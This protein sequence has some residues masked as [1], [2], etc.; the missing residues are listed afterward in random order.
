MSINHWSLMN[1]TKIYPCG[2]HGH[3]LA[4]FCLKPSLL[5][6]DVSVV[7]SREQN[8]SEPVFTESFQINGCKQS[9]RT[10]TRF[11]LICYQLFTIVFASLLYGSISD[12]L[13]T[14]LL[15]ECYFVH[16]N[17]LGYLRPA[18]LNPFLTYWH[19]SST[20][21]LFYVR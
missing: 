12:I 14:L 1:R 17:T 13:V 6:N 20:T 7:M 11:L 2:R 10:D 4:I 15:L 21:K 19:S 18:R 3:P 5:M 9:V 8:L 16:S